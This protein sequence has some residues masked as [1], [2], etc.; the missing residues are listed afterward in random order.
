MYFFQAFLIFLKSSLY[1]QSVISH[2]ILMKLHNSTC[3]FLWF[4]KNHTK[5]DQ[6]YQPIACW[7]ENCLVFLLMCCIFNENKYFGRYVMCNLWTFMLNPTYMKN[8]RME[9]SLHTRK[10]R[11]CY[12]SFKF[13]HARSMVLLWIPPRA[14]FNNSLMHTIPLIVL[15]WDSMPSQNIVMPNI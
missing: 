5:H 6:V 15:V 1:V 8:L 3:I 4:P 14:Y 10:Y 11:A 7:K 13:L 12:L 2:T 9:V